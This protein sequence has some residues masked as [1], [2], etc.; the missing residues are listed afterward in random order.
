M[1]RDSGPY[2]WVTPLVEYE[3]EVVGRASGMGQLAERGGGS[4]WIG[5]EQVVAEMAPDREQ[6]P[7]RGPGVDRE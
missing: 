4:L 5:R 7:E 2:L 6:G 3:A 1:W